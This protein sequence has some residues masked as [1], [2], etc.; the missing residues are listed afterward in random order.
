MGGWMGPRAG[1]EALKHFKEPSLAPAAK[2]TPFEIKQIPKSRVLL[3]KLA[4][5]SLPNKYSAYFGTQK[6]MPHLSFV[7]QCLSFPHV[8]QSSVGTHFCSLQ[9]VLYVMLI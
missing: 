9:F 3:D 7:C 5:A 1:L 2:Q 6:F 4:V 8:L